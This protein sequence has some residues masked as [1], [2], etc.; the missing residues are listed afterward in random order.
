MMRRHPCSWL[1][2]VAGLLLLAGHALADKLPL[3]AVEGG[4]SR[5]LLLGSIHLLKADSGTLP[6]AIITAYGQSDLLVME[7]DINGIDL[8]ATQALIGQL[9]FDAEGR[10]LEQL[11][12]PRDWQRALRAAEDAGITLARYRDFKPWFAATTIMELQ[13]GQLGYGAALGVEG[14]LAALARRDGKRIEGL[15]SVA[16]QL[17][18]LDALSAGAQSAFLL[19]TLDEISDFQEQAERMTRA[20]QQG[21]MKT[22]EADFLESLRAQP[23]LYQRIVVERNRSWMGRLG[24]ILAGDRDSLVVVGTLHLVGEDSV[25]GLL[26]KAGYR[27][28]QLGRSDLP[29]SADGPLKGPVVAD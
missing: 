29:S 24:Q 16:E 5:M 26:E 18:S 27:V 1:L 9:A 28:R 10:D 8:L 14:Q 22:L 7:I 15:E 3:W 6:E 11:L 13:L 17:G 12:G 20:W 25:S 21:D 4:E 23:E 19:A 2:L